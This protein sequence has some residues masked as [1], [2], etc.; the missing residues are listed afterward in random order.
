[1]NALSKNVKNVG[2]QAKHPLNRFEMHESPL[3]RLYGLEYSCDSRQE[4]IVDQ[5]KF[6]C[7]TAIRC[8]PLQLRYRIETIK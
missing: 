6:I 8:W 1:M 7:F 5:L 4:M 2:E 3:K